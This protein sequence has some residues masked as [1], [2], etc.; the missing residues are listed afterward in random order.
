MNRFLVKEKEMELIKME[1]M[2][3][4]LMTLERR[5]RQP[6]TLAQ[7]LLAIKDQ[8]FLTGRLK[9]LDDSELWNDFDCAVV[10]AE[11]KGTSPD[12]NRNSVIRELLSRLDLHDSQIQDTTSNGL[13]T[14]S[15]WKLLDM[16]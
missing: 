13:G 5:V 10:E 3:E 12:K 4:T 9:H 7:A 16:L 8:C 6:L 11:S 15:T 1:A 2:S 14:L